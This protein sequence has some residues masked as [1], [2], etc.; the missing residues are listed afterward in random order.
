M[1]GRGGLILECFIGCFF[2]LFLV[3]ASQYF[4]KC[5]WDFAHFRHCVVAAAF[6]K[7]QEEQEQLEDEKLENILFGHEWSEG[8]STGNQLMIIFVYFAN[9]YETS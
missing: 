1:C 8:S 5:Y 9:N 6:K 7:I 2:F 4:K 3:I